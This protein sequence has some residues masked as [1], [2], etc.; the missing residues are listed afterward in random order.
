MPRTT[1][2]TETRTVPHPLDRARAA[3]EQALE[4]LGALDLEAKAEGDSHTVTGVVGSGF[5]N[6]N[7][8]CLTVLLE[9]IDENQTRAR[10][11]G[12]AKEGLIPQ[13]SAAKA[14]AR[15]FAA[16]GGN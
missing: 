11:R 12:T 5:F 10:V 13:N 9:P 8:V 4:T 15:L 2:Q 6:M 7:P 16:W 3:L 1:E 14:I